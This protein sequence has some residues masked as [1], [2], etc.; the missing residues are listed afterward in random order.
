MILQEQYGKLSANISTL[1]TP[2][3]FG[4]KYAADTIQ[5]SHLS[6]K[7]L[8]KLACWL[9]QRLSLHK[10]DLRPLIPWVSPISSAA[11]KLTYPLGR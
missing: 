9:W 11:T 6:Y 5:L 3:T 7:C 1:L 10:N 2:A 4:N 8:S